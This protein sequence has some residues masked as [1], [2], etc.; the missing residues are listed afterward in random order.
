MQALK[1]E[2]RGL[3]PSLSRFNVRHFIGDDLLSVVLTVRGNYVST[4]INQNGFVFH[5]HL[6]FQFEWQS[7]FM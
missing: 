6:R 2:K 4:S 1:Q 7:F 5:Y 3:G